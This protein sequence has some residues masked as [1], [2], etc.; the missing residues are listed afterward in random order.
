MSLLTRWHQ[1]SQLQ[2]GL[3]FVMLK[4]ICHYCEPGSRTC[5]QYPGTHW[6]IFTKSEF[7]LVYVIYTS[8]TE[9]HPCHAHLQSVP[10]SIFG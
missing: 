10:A 1:G 4:T 6:S 5:T 2:L 9:E 7:N 8:A 3:A